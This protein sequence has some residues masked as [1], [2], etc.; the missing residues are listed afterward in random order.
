MSMSVLRRRITGLIPSPI[1]TSTAPPIALSVDIPP[2]PQRPEPVRHVPPVP[3]PVGP[4]A[5]AVTPT[6]KPPSWTPGVCHHDFHATYDGQR[7]GV[8]I[9]DDKQATWLACEHVS[10]DGR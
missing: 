10:K 3:V 4:P 6:P 5:A 8:L 7:I 1:T 2:T 9:L